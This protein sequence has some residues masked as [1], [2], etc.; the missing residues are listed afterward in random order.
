MANAISGW[1]AAR[2]PI[3]THL[4]ANLKALCGMHEVTA[5][6][7]AEA[8]GAHPDTAYDHMKCADG[9]APTAALALRLSGAFG[10]R[11]A[12]LWGDRGSALRHAA[13]AYEDAP[14]RSLDAPGFKERFSDFMFDHLRPEEHDAYLEGSPLPDMSSQDRPKHAMYIVARKHRW[15]YLP[16]DLITGDPPP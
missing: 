3:T 13:A 9:R 14:I 11:P 5:P 15:R 16:P 12:D 2:M 6:Q 7:L 8:V 1:Y 4:A 10:V